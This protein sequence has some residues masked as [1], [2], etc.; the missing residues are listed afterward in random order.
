[1]APRAVP[2]ASIPFAPAAGP[3]VF[4]PPSPLGF[5]P[6]ANGAACPPLG[7]PPSASD[8]EANGATLRPPITPAPQAAATP[9]QPVEATAPEPE[10][11]VVNLA[12]LAEGW[13]EAVRK[14]VVDLNLVD[15]KVALPYG[16]IEQAL[17]L[18]RIAFSWK[19]LRSWI[20][21][22]PLP[23][24]SAQDGTVLELPLKV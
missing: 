13:P 1:P 5:S 12:S 16:A 11:L 6:A 3:T 2:A 7:A 14:E 15:A 10:P 4:S 21:P 23:I 9:A 20:K 18:G 22:A 24:G 17:R 19:T 8:H